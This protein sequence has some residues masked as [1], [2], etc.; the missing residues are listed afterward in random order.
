MVFH[1]D[2]D[3][4]RGGWIKEHNMVLCTLLRFNPVI[5][6]THPY[7]CHMYIDLFSN[8]LKYSRIITPEN[9]LETE[10]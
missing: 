4:R 10:K 7:P 8:T 6:A 5:V 1:G 2:F 3:G 9:I